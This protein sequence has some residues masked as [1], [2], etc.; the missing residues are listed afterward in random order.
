MFGAKIKMV[1][2]K[3]ETEEKVKCNFCSS[4]R[5]SKAGFVG[6]AK[7]QRYYCQDCQ[8]FFRENAVYQTRKK[9]YAPKLDLL[10]DEQQLIS[11]LQL[12]AQTLGKTPTTV[13]IAR[14]SKERKS[15]SVQ[16]YYAV[17]GSFVN[18]VKVAKLKQHYRQEFDKEKLL[19]ELKE[20]GKTFNRPVFARDVVAARRKSLISPPHHFQ[21]A[22]GSVANA[23]EASE[24]NKKYPF[25][26]F[27]Y[28]PR[29]KGEY[30]PRAKHYSREELIKHLKKLELKIG[31]IP[32]GNDIEKNY[33]KDVNPSLKAYLREFGS[34]SNARKAA[35]IPNT[36]WQKFSKTEL[37]EQLK[38][39][40]EKLGRKP[41]DRDIV[42]ACAAGETAS[43]QVFA[44]NFG[45]LTKAYEAAG[46]EILKPKEYSDREIIKRLRKLRQ[47]L[48]K[49]IGWN[50]LK[51]ASIEGWCPAPNTVYRRV[52]NVDK[53]EEI[54]NE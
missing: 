12:I 8:R 46:F 20:L 19:A 1:Y 17:F 23:I 31:H 44:N 22:F 13:D 35:Q 24:I 21:K 39:L 2:R 37:I 16:N 25:D 42:R 4:E 29:N 27:N 47:K 54:L 48:G 34:L 15:H 49:K 18:A 7:K 10:P 51:R 11:E 50:D 28:L 6:K 33:K 26:D 52:G 53:I 30:L 45:S 43:A 3:S 5:T 14:L 32:R 40:G 38:K 9:S 41:S 36:Q